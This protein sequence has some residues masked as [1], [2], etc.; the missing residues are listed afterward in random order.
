MLWQEQFLKLSLLWAGKGTLGCL[1]W[2]T[3]L[4]DL[5]LPPPE[6]STISYCHVY[7]WPLKWGWKL[8]VWASGAQC[9][10]A[11]DHL[12]VGYSSGRAVF[13][14]SCKRPVPVV[15][16][17]F[18][19]LFVDIIVGGR[20]GPS[21]WGSRLSCPQFCWCYPKILVH[22]F[23]PFD[24][25][26]AFDSMHLFDLDFG[27]DLPLSGPHSPS[28]VEWQLAWFVWDSGCSWV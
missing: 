24:G 12:H 20:A 10:T 9:L 19:S 16:V 28:Q 21:K 27:T 4:H 17:S 6:L 25:H 15:P 18:R 1:L 3:L 14:I 13:P 26:S 2:K 5:V 7:L 22:A 23:F 8:F 11:C